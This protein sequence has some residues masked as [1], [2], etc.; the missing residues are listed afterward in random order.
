MTEIVWLPLA[1]CKFGWCSLPD[2]QKC[3]KLD[4]NGKPTTLVCEYFH[5]KHPNAG[6]VPEYIARKSK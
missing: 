1:C 5:K 6:T 3:N 2:G 4:G